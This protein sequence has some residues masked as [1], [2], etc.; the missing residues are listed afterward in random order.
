MIANKKEFYGGVGMM[1]AFLVVLIII[2]SPV[3]KGQNGLEYLD[4]LYN[5]ISKGSAYYIP[6]VKKESDNFIGSSVSLTLKMANETQA[7]Q[8][9]KLFN[10]AGALVNIS[11]AELKA[12]GDLG[13]ILENCLADAEDMYKNNGQA[14]SDKYG[15]D[16]KRVLFNWWKACKAMDKD[17]KKQGKFPEAKMVATVG[18][19]AVETSYNYYRVEP[20]KI[21]A[22]IGLVVFSLVFYVVYT[23]WYG[24]AIMFMFEGWGLKLEH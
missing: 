4:E 16:E 13:N 24:F 6:K 18:K 14:V 21:G 3:F 8:T 17:L 1:A 22:R 9:F 2:F 19:K 11:G 15:Y 12:T 7:E 23:L 20:Q 5:T 10:Q